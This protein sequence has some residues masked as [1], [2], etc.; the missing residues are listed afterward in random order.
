MEVVPEL[1]KVVLRY[2]N[3]ILSEDIYWG[4]VRDALR[5]QYLVLTFALQHKRNS[6]LHPKQGLNDFSWTST[7]K[8]CTGNFS[9]FFFVFLVLFYFKLQEH[10]RSDD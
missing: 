10:T 8:L 5:Y 3:N 7:H 9:F 6:K 2:P 1:M 4:F